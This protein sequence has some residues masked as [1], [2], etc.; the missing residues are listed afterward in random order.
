MTSQ[1]DAILAEILRRMAVA[2]ILERDG[3]AQA[4]AWAKGTDPAIAELG[5]RVLA[6]SLLRLMISIARTYETDAMPLARLAPAGLA[7]IGAAIDSFD[8]TK[9]FKL[10]TYAAGFIR[11]AITKN[12]EP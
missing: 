1:E 11:Q 6:D 10:Q 3:W 7:G 12:I 8:P 4:V 9:E 2:P 5:R